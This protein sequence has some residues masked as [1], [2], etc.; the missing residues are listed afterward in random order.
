[1]AFSYEPGKGGG[2]TG[3]VPGDGHGED[4]EEGSSSLQKTIKNVMNLV[5][6]GLYRFK[7][8]TKAE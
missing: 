7:N 5:N 4:D 1:M 2:A 8:R 3:I 6:D